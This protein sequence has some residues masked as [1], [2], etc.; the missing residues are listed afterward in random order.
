MMDANQFI[1]FMEHVQEEH[2]PCVHG[3]YDCSDTYLGRCSNEEYANLT[4]RER[5]IVE[6]QGY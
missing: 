1:E 3:H 4:V 2:Q 6:E 5:E